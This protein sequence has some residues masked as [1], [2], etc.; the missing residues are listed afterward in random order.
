MIQLYILIILLFIFILFILYN[1]IKQ[2][3][4]ISGI[5][6]D[7]LVNPGNDNVV[8]INN[9]YERLGNN[10]KQIV[11]GL[12]IM[13]EYNCN[14][15]VVP[16]HDLFYF[17]NLPKY[18]KNMNK[19][20][21]NVET[22]TNLFERNEIIDKYNYIDKSIFDN[23][24]AE[25]LKI[26]KNLFKIKY[27]DVHKYDNND[28]HIH[29]RSGDIFI[30]PVTWYMQPPLDFY[31]KI[32]ESRK[33]DKIYLLAEDNLNPTIDKLIELYPNIIWNKNN[34]EE[35]IKI[36]MG[37]KNI[38]FGIG[39]FIPNVLYFNEGLHEIFMPT[40]HDYNFS[41]INNI[42][43]NIIDLTDYYNML[44]CAI[45]LE[46]NRREGVWANTPEQLKIM[47]EYKIKQD[48]Y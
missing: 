3:F 27:K 15:I 45:G 11:N 36:I 40:R 10:M 33:Y 7:L 16:S 26:L 5:E 47:I 17:N 34:L 4:T 8:K 23:N 38:V 30:N 43:E 14:F 48:K 18:N 42:K 32:I 29:I 1:N 2:K 46:G 20:I 39:T 12:H 35:D 24:K 9:W 19:L 31:V 25:V 28:L 21:T 37:C 6:K 44:G 22:N 13:I 41:Y